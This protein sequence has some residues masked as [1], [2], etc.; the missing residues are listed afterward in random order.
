MPVEEFLGDDPFF[1][2]YEDTGKG[3]AVEAISEGFVG[4]D[5]GIEHAEAGD[6]FG[7]C[8]GEEW[9]GDSLVVGEF[10]EFVSGVVAD[11]TDLDAFGLEL[12]DALL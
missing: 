11:P 8:I 4:F 1:V 6:D 2:H 12:F 9:E 5:E 7:V 10:L 3:D